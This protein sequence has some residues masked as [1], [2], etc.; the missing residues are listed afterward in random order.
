MTDL[1][2]SYDPPQIRDWPK[3]PYRT[4]FIVMILFL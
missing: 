2:H 1:I 4:I 3:R